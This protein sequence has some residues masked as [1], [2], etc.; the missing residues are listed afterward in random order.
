MQLP[1]EWMLSSCMS[2]LSSVVFSAGQP[3]ARLED[4]TMTTCG[5]VRLLPITSRE[6]WYHLAL[7]GS[8]DLVGIRGRAHSRTAALLS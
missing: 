1:S 6:L 4:I 2:L 7:R 3:P 8:H 5:A